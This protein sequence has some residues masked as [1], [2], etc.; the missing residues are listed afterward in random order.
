M[1]AA[2]YQV[3]AFK[4]IPPEGMAMLVALGQPRS[5]ETGSTLMRQGDPSDALHVL[6]T[7]RVRVQREIPDAAPFPLAELGPG[8]V[9]GEMGVLDNEPRSATVT[10]IQPTETV[11]ISGAAIGTVILRYPEVASGLLRTISQRIRNSDELAEQ[12]VTRALGTVGRAPIVE[13]QDNSW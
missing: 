3:E 1:L 8:E 6:V 12:I 11:E 4:N 7:G 9:V 5:F 10:A 13:P 2:L